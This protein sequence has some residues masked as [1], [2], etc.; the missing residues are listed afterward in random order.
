MPGS[1]RDDS[2]RIA[3]ARDPGLATGLAALSSFA[4]AQNSAGSPA[5]DYIDTQACA[6][7]HAKIYENYQRTGMARSFYRPQPASMVEDYRATIATITSHP[8]PT[9]R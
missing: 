8:T 1:S 5:K 6:R 3:V 2:C 7:C 9:S 4:S